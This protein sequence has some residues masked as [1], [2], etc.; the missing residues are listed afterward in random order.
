MRKPDYIQTTLIGVVAKT[1]D[2]VLPGNNL[3]ETGPK[4]LEYIGSLTYKEFAAIKKKIKLGKL[5]KV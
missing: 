2:C 1:L 3:T 5:P 4:L